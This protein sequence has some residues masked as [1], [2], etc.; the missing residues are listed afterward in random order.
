MKKKVD[1]AEGLMDNKLFV[2]RWVL[3]P[4]GHLKDVFVV[5][6]FIV[7]GFDHHMSFS[8]SGIHLIQY[9]SDRYFIP[10]KYPPIPVPITDNFHD[11]TLERLLFSPFGGR[12]VA[13]VGEVVFIGSCVVQNV[14][15]GRYFFLR[16]WL[17]FLIIIAENVSNTGG[18]FLEFLGEDL[19]M[20]GMG[21]FRGG[22]FQNEK[23]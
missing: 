12:L 1:R 17:V 10:S 8:Q 23:F 21:S 15:H 9:S 6:L 20:S 7:H 14:C 3:F 2:G 19:R 18:N 13:A 5:S 11:L 4:C 22:F 16:P